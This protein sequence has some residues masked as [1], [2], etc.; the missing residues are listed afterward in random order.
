[1]RRRRRRRRRGGFGWGPRNAPRLWLRDADVAVPPHRLVVEEAQREGVR[2]LQLPQTRDHGV[3]REPHRGAVH[4][5]AHVQQEHDLLAARRHGDGL[6]RRAQQHCEGRRL[7]AEALLHHEAADDVRAREAVAENEVLIA[8]LR[9]GDG[10][11]TAQRRP[12]DRDALCVDDS[13]R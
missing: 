12:Q 4:A 10:L 7:V 3:D 13:D 8:D 11:H 6:Q 9:Q 1:M 2:R 5:A